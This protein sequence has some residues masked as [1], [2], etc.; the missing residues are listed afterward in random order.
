MPETGKVLCNTC[1]LYFPAPFPAPGGLYSL[2]HVCLT[3]SS[4]SY[5][6]TCC[7][8]WLSRR[9]VNLMSVPDLAALGCKDLSI[10][11]SCMYGRFVFAS[12][13]RDRD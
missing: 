9:N 1:T 10:V 11:C 2:G 5:A 6:E 4:G 3:V 12:L 13:K 8:A 7:S